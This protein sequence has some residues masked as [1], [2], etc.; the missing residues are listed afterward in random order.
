[1]V[2]NLSKIYRN[3]RIFF[4]SRKLIEELRYELDTLKSELDVPK[5]LLA[6][7]YS[8]RKKVDL[9]W[10][11]F[12]YERKSGRWVLN[13]AR[14]YVFRQVTA[15][16]IFYHRWFSAI[17]RD[18]EAIVTMSRVIGTGCASSCI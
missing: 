11:P 6:C 14:E 16:S 15:A 1:M 7:F 8:E 3:L 9:V 13:K 2:D 4:N 5:E 17:P 18:I 10:H 12:W